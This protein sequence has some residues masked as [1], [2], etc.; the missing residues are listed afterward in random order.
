[1]KFPEP[2]TLSELASLLSCR[3]VGDPG[4][5]ALGMNE[6]HQVE[7]GDVSF[8]DHPKYY[9]ACLGS[10]ASVVIINKEV[11][12]PPGKGL[13]ISEDPFADFNKLGR[14]YS[15]FVSSLKLQND[16]AQIGEGTIIQPNVFI[17]N[18]VRI[19]K[20]C[21]IHP[22]VTIYDNT[23]IGNNVEVH[24]NTVLGSDA[25]YYKNRGT[26]REKLWSTGYLEIA[27]DVEIGAGCTIDRGVSGVTYIG[28]ATKID[29]LVQI[30]HDT[31][32]GEM[33]LFAAQVGIA[34]CVKVGKNVTL[35][36]K[37]GVASGVEI[38]DN[39]VVLGASG[40]GKNLE[41]NKTYAGVLAQEARAHWKQQVSLKSLPD[42]IKKVK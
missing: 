2:L 10:S 16:K 21:L 20:N 1:M 29:N 9:A 6:I 37:V 4:L 13:L 40:V 5:Q 23:I 27:D 39:V 32:I 11:E 30:G 8:V 17:G 7:A 18:D 38:G 3:Y 26:H 42:L 35:W 19:G 36:G 24:A 31:V 15:P 12:C 34:G 25:F 28:R 33:G 22:N 14:K 41:A